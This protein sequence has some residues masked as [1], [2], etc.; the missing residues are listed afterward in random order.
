M[1]ILQTFHVY[2]FEQIAMGNNNTLSKLLNSGIS[3]SLRDSSQVDDSLLHWAVSF[4]NPDALKI[5]CID[6][7]VDI[8]VANRNGQTPLH[9]A[10]KG[11]NQTLIDIIL[12][13]GGDPTIRDKEGKDC[14]DV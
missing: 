7:K 6:N 5:L 13:L 2:L 11:S 12:D 3:S 14:L 10:C 9:I 8:N 4:S 1:R